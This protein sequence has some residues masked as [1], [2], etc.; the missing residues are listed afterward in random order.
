MKLCLTKPRGLRP[1]LALENI[2]IIRFCMGINAKLCIFF[3][4]YIYLYINTVLLLQV[5]VFV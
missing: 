3:N 5:V 4:I 2:F 1:G